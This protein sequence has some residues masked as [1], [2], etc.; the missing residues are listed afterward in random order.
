LDQRGVLD[1]A[2]VADGLG[3]DVVGAENLWMID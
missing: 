3:E 1:V 2:G